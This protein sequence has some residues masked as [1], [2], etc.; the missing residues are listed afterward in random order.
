[1]CGAS[2]TR[3]DICSYCYRHPAARKD[4]GLSHRLLAHH[5]LVLHASN[6]TKNLLFPPP[7]LQHLFQIQ[8][9]AWMSA[10]LSE[11]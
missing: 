9:T 7:H 1:M 6:P 11:M 4:V 2:M 3:T 10:M 5:P 8:M